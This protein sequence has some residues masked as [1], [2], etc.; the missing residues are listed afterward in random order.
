MG[1]QGGDVKGTTRT[2]N[3]EGV[4]EA[5][6]VA[7]ASFEPGYDLGKGMGEEGQTMAD[8]KRGFSNYGK[9]TGA[10]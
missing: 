9:S 6:S 7:S 10:K 2:D 5:V 3:S 4:G 8:L 1:N